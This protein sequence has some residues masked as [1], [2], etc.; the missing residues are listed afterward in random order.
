MRLDETKKVLTIHHN[1]HRRGRCRA[2]GCTQFS[3]CEHGCAWSDKSQTHC[4]ACF[5]HQCGRK[6]LSTANYTYNDSGYRICRARARC[7]A[8]QRRNVADGQIVKAL[9]KTR[10]A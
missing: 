7:Q 3:P 8:Q 5:C 6:F 2:C 4:T 9:E 1:G 10:H